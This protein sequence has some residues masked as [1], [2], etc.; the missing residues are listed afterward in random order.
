MKLSQHTLKE[1]LE[2][3]HDQYNRPE[4]IS[5]DPIAIPHSF[6]RKE[7]IEIS[8]FLVAS[9]AWGQR[10]TIIANGKRLMEIMGS[11]P[12]DFIMSNSFDN[13]YN[14]RIAKFKH[15]T[16]NGQDCNYFM[17]S[18]KNIYNHHGGLEKVFTDG[19][20][21]TNG[22]PKLAISA[23]KELFFLNDYP[24]RT[25]K[26]VS[27]PGKN[28]AAKRI[29]MFLRWMVRSDNRGV[30]FGLW[31]GINKKNLHL[32]LDAHTGNVSRKLGI[33]KRKQNDWKAVAEVTAALRKL[34][35][36]DPVK[37]DYSLFGLGVF[38]KF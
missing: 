32:P 20:T 38:E 28:S 29:N 10:K 14:D 17:H 13:I 30:D 27:D 6:D 15:R 11:S 31:E 8:G 33:L 21:K 1:F 12:Y 9:F 2:E 36:N 22:N 16:F 23:F 24:V 18:L 25:K 4:F 35:H 26:H 19:F 37:Y 3:K 5:T 7:D 34:D